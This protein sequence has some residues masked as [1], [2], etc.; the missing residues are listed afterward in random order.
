MYYTVLTNKKNNKKLVKCFDIYWF[1]IS[2][3]SREKKIKK[4]IFETENGMSKPFKLIDIDGISYNFELSLGL[5]T[6]HYKNNELYSIF[7]NIC[8]IEKVSKEQLAKQY[9]IELLQG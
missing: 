4:I 1:F 8:Q 3:E 5:S 7:K 2:N 6:P 9:F